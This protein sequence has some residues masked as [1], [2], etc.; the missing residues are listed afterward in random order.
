MKTKGPLSKTTF[1]S[2]NSLEGTNQTQRQS[3]SVHKTKN[4]SSHYATQQS[5]LNESHNNLMQ[6][7]LNLRGMDRDLAEMGK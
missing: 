4:N 3:Y 5:K 1:R 7:W 2:T 6:S